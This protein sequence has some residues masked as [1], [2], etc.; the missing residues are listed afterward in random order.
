MDNAARET[1]F[2]MTG[3]VFHQNRKQPWTLVSQHEA[4]CFSWQKTS[5]FFTTLSNI[6]SVTVY[7][8]FKEMPRLVSRGFDRSGDNVFPV[9]PRWLLWVESGLDLACWPPRLDVLWL[10]EPEKNTCT[11]LTTRHFYSMRRT[12]GI[13]PRTWGST[14]V[15]LDGR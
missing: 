4:R 12:Y 2:T 3:A 6:P 14:T 10:E 5:H 9:F 1:N 7:L 11:N 15:K 8:V 13:L